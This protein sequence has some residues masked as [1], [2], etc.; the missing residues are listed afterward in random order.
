LNK[1]LCLSLPVLA[2]M[3]L[4]VS[5]PAADFEIG[6]QDSK[7]SD[8]GTPDSGPISSRGD[9]KGGLPPAEVPTPLSAGDVPTAYGLS[10]YEMRADLAFY[11][12]GGILGKAYL[13]LFPQFLIGGAANVRGFIGSSDLAM[14]RDDAQLLAKLIV[15]KEDEAFPALAIGW[16]GPAYDRGEAKGLY[17]ALSKELP[18]AVGYIQLHGGLNSSQVQSFVATRD[19]RASAALTGAIHNFGFFTSVDEVLDPVA[20]R[21]DAGFEGHFSPIT[22]GLEWQDLASGRPDTK[23]SRLLRVSWLGRF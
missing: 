19:L 1:T 5:L 12:G 6:P 17:I 2:L 8:I 13:G 3:A 18:T 7:P 11:E 21:W 15:I 4:A 9:T 14:T 20:P 10:K 22:L 23:P 16:D